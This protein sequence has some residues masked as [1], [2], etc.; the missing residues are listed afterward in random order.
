[1][2]DET[3]DLEYSETNVGSA[4][5]QGVR[6]NISLK[7]KP[8]GRVRGGRGRGAKGKRTSTKKAT[9]DVPD[10][11]IEESTDP[12]VDKPSPEK[13]FVN[14]NLDDVISKL[15]TSAFSPLDRS[16]PEPTHREQKLRWDHK[17]NLIGEKVID[18]LIHCCEKCSLPIL[19]YGR[20]IPCKHVCCYDCS[21][22]CDKVCPKCEE[23]VQRIEQTTLGTVFMCNYGGGKHLPGACGRTYLSQRDLQA[24]MNHRHLKP[25]SLSSNNSSTTA[26]SHVSS[27]TGN[28]ATI[29]SG[30]PPTRD[31][32]AHLH[33]DVSH[34]PPMMGHVQDHREPPV[35]HSRSTSVPMGSPVGQLRQYPHSPASYQTSI[36][37][38][39]ARPNLITVPIQDDG[40]GLITPVAQPPPHMPHP[41]QHVP[42]P[43]YPP[44]AP[45][46]Y[47]PHPNPAPAYSQAPPMTTQTFPQPPPPV[48]HQPPI[49]GP[50]YSTP[51]PVV[52]HPPPT[53]YT[54]PRGPQQP[55]PPQ[56]FPQGGTYEEN[57]AY[58]QQWA[59]GGVP[60]PPNRAALPP[61]RPITAPPP[62]RN[63]NVGHIQP[64]GPSDPAYRQ[65]YYQ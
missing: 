32:R 9:L 11:D 64:R 13:P 29:G 65:P 60:P 48:H 20:M 24:H 27:T 63:P 43:Q 5:T 54:P 6:K 2:A 21:K 62:A 26:S 37:V 17:V 47:Q 33:V 53:T 44:T 1:M 19:N 52:H 31:P 38:S 41:Q 61:P 30:H 46:Y 16:F 12:P 3:D 35:D 40:A 49:G 51:P 25:A 14:S 39:S 7:L 10:D 50:I 55:M 34:Q 58:M 59:Q 42:P 22:K 23:K 18:P 36:P 57:P 56:H 4:Q 45:A 8:K 28:A 15:E